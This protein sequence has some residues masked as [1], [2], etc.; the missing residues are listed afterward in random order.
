LFSGAGGISELV[1]GFG[2]AV[3]NDSPVSELGRRL[4]DKGILQSLYEVWKF[5]DEI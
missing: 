4:I 2:I 3:T 1:E 5:L